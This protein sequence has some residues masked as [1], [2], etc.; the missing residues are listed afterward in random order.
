MP[1]YRPGPAPRSSWINAHTGLTVGLIGLVLAVLAIFA[2]DWV[3]AFGVFQLDF[4]KF[5]AMSTASGNDSTD[6]TSLVMRLFF[7]LGGYAMLA[8][9]AI[10]VVGAYV[11]RGQRKPFALL[12][13]ICGVLGAI[14]A[15][16]FVVAIHTAL[17]NATSTAMASGDSVNGLGAM[18][19]S[20]GLG[21][22]VA[23]LGFLATAAACSILSMSPAAPPVP[24]MPY[25]DPA[26]AGPYPNRPSPLGPQPGYH[27]GYAPQYDTQFGY[28]DADAVAPQ[29]YQG[30][31]PAAPEQ[32]AAPLYHPNPHQRP[33]GSHRA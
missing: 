21:P 1:S 29:H 16:W 12:G 25:A 33:G 28:P 13:A 18:T 27:G 9:C 31:P 10:G 3:S 32:P 20:V 15:L 26:A 11:V 24:A 7:G 14:P 4:S 17:A 5:H 8:L 23:V 6:L 19:V 22:W 30:Y 2:L